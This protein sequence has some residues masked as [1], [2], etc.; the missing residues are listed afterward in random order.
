M[1]KII[2]GIA[3][4]HVPAIGAALETHPQ[5]GDVASELADAAMAAGDDD[6][7]LK[8]LRVVALQKGACPM[9]KA[10][11]FVHQATLAK[12]QGDA[13]KALFFARKAELED[14]ALPEARALV[15]E[16]TAG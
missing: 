5:S 9:S 4:S 13:K 8:A 15:M 11:A 3:S 16:L 2:A 6:L 14:P 12:R 1:A 10:M 7:A